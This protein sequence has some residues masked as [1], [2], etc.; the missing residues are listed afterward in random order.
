MNPFLDDAPE[1]VPVSS[2]ATVSQRVEEV[3]PKKVLPPPPPLQGPVLSPPE[4]VAQRPDLSCFEVQRRQRSFKV[5]DRG[6]FSPTAL[7]SPG[8]G[9]EVWAEWP[10]LGRGSAIL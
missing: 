9:P 8:L 2:N 10:T 3:L 4:G 5:S 1:D 7:P 6:V